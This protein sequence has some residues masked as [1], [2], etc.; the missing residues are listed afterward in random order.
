MSVFYFGNIFYAF[1]LFYT[2]NFFEWFTLF[3]DSYGTK[4]FKVILS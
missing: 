4:D 2:Y 1:G 3:G